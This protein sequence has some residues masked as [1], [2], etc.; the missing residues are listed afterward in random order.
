[1]ERIQSLEYKDLGG[2]VLLLVPLLSL[3][4]LGCQPSLAL[5]GLVLRPRLLRRLAGLPFGEPG[6]GGASLCIIYTMSNNTQTLCIH[7]FIKF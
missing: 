3:A 7:L 5:G 4:K 2:M 6:I 1:M